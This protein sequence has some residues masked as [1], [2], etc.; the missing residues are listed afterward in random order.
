MAN[1]WRVLEF[2]KFAGEWPLLRINTFLVQKTNLTESGN[3]LKETKKRRKNGLA[4]KD[5]K[6]EGQKPEVVLFSGR[7]VVRYVLDHDLHGLDRDHRR[8]VLKMNQ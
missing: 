3:I 4:F 7:A 2:D 1:F 8:V 6:I 5:L